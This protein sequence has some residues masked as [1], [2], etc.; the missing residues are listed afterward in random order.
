MLL[1]GRK[2]RLPSMGSW[3]SSDLGS[4]LCIGLSRARR[5]PLV[6]LLGGERG[7]NA[8]SLPGGD[9]IFGGNADDRP[10]GVNGLILERSSN[11]PRAEFKTIEEA[12]EAA[13][14]IKNRRLDTI[15]GV[16]PWWC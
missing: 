5:N 9:R 16:L 2:Q 1:N 12:H 4:L 3:C 6:R 10:L 14:A 13:K 15:L 11:E 7:S 8:L